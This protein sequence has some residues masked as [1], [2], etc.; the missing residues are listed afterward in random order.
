MLYHA[1]D[2][3]QCWSKTAIFLPPDF[4]IQLRVLASEFWNAYGI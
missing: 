2:E 4:D 1:R 3:W